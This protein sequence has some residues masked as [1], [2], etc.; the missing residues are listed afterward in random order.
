M[1]AKGQ[2]VLPKSVR[3]AFKLYPGCKVSISVDDRG[4]LVLVPVLHEP[5]ELF[6][7]RPPVRRIRSV[8]GMDRAI[9]K[10]VRARV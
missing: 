4:R 5:E 3:E 6:A 7:D 10:A 2:F 9:G 1:S 8:G